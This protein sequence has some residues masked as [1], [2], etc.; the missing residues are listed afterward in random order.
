MAT[1]FFFS[2]ASATLDLTPPGNLSADVDLQMNLVRDAGLGVA[3]ANT[4]AGPTS[5]VQI[6]SITRSWWTQPLSAV[7]ISGTVTLN[8]WM[9]ET[10]MSA[11]VG[12]QVTIDWYDNS[13]TSLKGTVLNSEKGTEVP[14]TTRAAQ[15][16]TAAPTSSA[17]ANGDRLRIRVW[18][19]DVGTMGSGFGFEFA[20]GAPSAA[21]DGDSWVQF[22]EAVSLYTAAPSLVYHDRKVARNTLLRR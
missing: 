8:V 20:S 22:T 14:V 17:L 2:S 12:A 13:G 9:S 19:N 21:A 11:N 15:N 3:G 4:V 10:N 6:G 18:G 7:T 16:W 1:Q 5:G